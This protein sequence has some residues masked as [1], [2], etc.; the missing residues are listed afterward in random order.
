M[1]GVNKLNY[2]KT[3]VHVSAS[4]SIL[5]VFKTNPTQLYKYHIR[6]M[7][8]CQGRVTNNGR[9]KPNYTGHELQGTVTSN[10]RPKPNY[11]GYGLQGTG[12]K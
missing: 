4:E 10:G 5:S 9:P 3:M 12:Y 6:N 1:S 7:G 2:V 11:I 8:V